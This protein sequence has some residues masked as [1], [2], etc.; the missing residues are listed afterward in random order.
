MVGWDLTDLCYC[1]SYVLFAPSLLSSWIYI[2]AFHF[3]SSLGFF[4]CFFKIALGITIFLNYHNIPWICILSLHLQC[5]TE[6]QK[7]NTT[8]WNLWDSALGREK[9]YSDWKHVGWLEPESHSKPM[10]RRSH[11]EAPGASRKKWSLT[12][13]TTGRFWF[14]Q[15][16]FAITFC[17]TERTAGVIKL[18]VFII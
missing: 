16:P 5:K 9:Q 13:Q 11:V 1:L 6:K 12:I 17:I 15:E 4:N 8:L 3:I 2:L 7:Q 18:E 14:S 10:F